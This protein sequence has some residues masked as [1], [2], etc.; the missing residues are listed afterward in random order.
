VD[1]RNDYARR[2]SKAAI[3]IL[4]LTALIWLRS[5]RAPAVET[6]EEAHA[7]ALETY[8]YFYPLVTMDLTR[9][10]LT[11]VG[12]GEELGKGPMNTFAHVPEY[13]PA[14]FRTK[15]PAKTRSQPGFP[16]RKDHSI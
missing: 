11:N 8:I 5:S 14:D 10:Q 9:R 15:A 1:P 16:R 7:I 3:L 6:A 4:L 13:P 12:P 2:Y